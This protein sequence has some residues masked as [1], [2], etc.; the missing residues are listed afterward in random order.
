MKT[1]IKIRAM[2]LKKH[3]CEL[4]WSYLCVGVIMLLVGIINIINMLKER[5][6]LLKIDVYKQK[7]S[8]QIDKTKSYLFNIGLI[9]EDNQI[10]ESFKQFSK[11][12]NNLNL[13]FFI[14]EKDINDYKQFSE[15]IEIKNLNNTFQIIIKR[16]KINIFENI[17]RK[18]FKLPSFEN[19]EN[20][21]KNII[22][23]FLLNYTNNTNLK[24]VNIY[25][26]KMEIEKINS[27]MLLFFG[28]IYVLE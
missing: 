22:N 23:E 9:S 14:K 21:L 17:I 24:D 3:P 27:S 28:V 11:S 16:H 15:I 8:N 20:Y 5:I 25:S 26:L 10:I 13:S 12:Y 1:L 4:F 18:Y 19:N 7:Y 2:Y 6:S